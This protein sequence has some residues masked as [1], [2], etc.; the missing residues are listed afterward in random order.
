MEYDVD[1]R[2]TNQTDQNGKI[3]TYLYDVRDLLTKKTYGASGEQIFTWDVMRRKTQDSDN[4]S[5]NQ[6]IIMGYEF[7]KLS[8]MT[9]QTQKIGSGA[10]QNITKL[11]DAYGRRTRITYPHGR[12]VDTT[13]TSLHQVNEIKTDVGSGIVTVADYDYLYDMG[14]VDKRPLLT[15]NTLTSSTDT[16]VDF[17]Y[18]SIGRVTKKNWLDISASTTLVGFEYTYNLFG[19]RL[20]DN[21]LDR[22][23]DSETFLYDTAQRLTKYERGTI[24]GTPSFYQGY[25]LDALAN[26]STFNNN[27]SS[28]SR[29]HNAMNAVTV[30]GSTSL[31]YDANGNL[32]DD[33]NQKYVWDE[34][35]RLVEVRDSSSNI[36]CDY[37][38]NVENLRVEKHHAGGTKEQFYYSGATV[39]VETDGSQNKVREYVNGGQY[40]DEVILVVNGS[41]YNYYMS[42]LRYCVTGFIDSSGTVV[43]RARYDGYGKRALLDATYTPIATANVNQSY[44]YSGIRHDNESGLQYYRARY[45]DNVLGRFINRDPIGYKDGM[46]LYRGYF[47]SNGLDPSGLWK[48]TKAF[49]GKSRGPFAGEVCSEKGDTLTA[50]AKSITGNGQDHNLIPYMGVDVNPGVKIDVTKLLGK[51]EKRLRNA[52]VDGTQGLNIVFPTFNPNTKTWSPFETGSTVTSQNLNSF[53]NSSASPPPCVDCLGAAR[54]ILFKGLTD[55][56]G[57]SLYSTATSPP[58][59]E[60]SGNATE[61]KLGDWGYFENDSTYMSTRNPETSGGYMGENVIKNGDDSF[62]GWPLGSKSEQGWLDSLVDAFNDNGTKKNGVADI[63]SVPGWKADAVKF[64]DVAGVA[65]DSFNKS[66]PH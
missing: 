50:L 48:I 18:D 46:N 14:G 44:G 27:G 60:P 30:R 3:S 29:T 43:E 57:S 37:Y 58:M 66:F 12:T 38:Y 32:T 22:S 34:L 6:T 16:R 45:F 35:N 9:K 4:N 49:T 10:T 25:T 65:T 54:I 64:W 7:D 26:W 5:G 61:A 62:F 24:G 8:S 47:I 52:V 63:T 19:N 40:I 39:L 41:A 2:I 13:Y 33:G 21:H 1:G 23:Q 15:K 42:D 28:E 31:T 17:A 59:D 11:Y 56:L 55:V 53:Y 20:T 51:L 36:I